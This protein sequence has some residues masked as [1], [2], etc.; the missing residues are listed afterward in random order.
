M[1]HGPTALKPGNRKKDVYGDKPLLELLR[2]FDE[3]FC[4]HP[5]T[6]VKWMS[7]RGQCAVKRHPWNDRGDEGSIR[8]RQK[9]VESVGV[10]LDE[11]GCARFIQTEYEGVDDEYGAAGFAT[12]SKGLER[13]VIADGMKINPC[14]QISFQNGVNAKVT[15]GGAIG[16]GGLSAS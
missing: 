15:R 16:S 6:N 10:F 5:K 7:S 2:R 8:A 11:R 13:A 12:L 14:V 9:T 1:P 3:V 4:V